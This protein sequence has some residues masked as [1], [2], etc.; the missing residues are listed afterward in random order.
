MDVKSVLCE[1][2]WSFKNIISNLLHFKQLH[3]ERYM[4]PV[5]IAAN[6]YESQDME[7]PKCSLIEE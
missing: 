4:H 7:A 2:L 6:V 5:F 1:V 3:S